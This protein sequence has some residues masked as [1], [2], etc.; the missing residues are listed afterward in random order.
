[1]LVTAR[2]APLRY[3]GV[4]DFQD[5]KSKLSLCCGTVHQLL[6]NGSEPQSPQAATKK[7]SNRRS[8]DDPGK[9]HGGRREHASNICCA[10]D[11]RDLLNPVT[12]LAGRRS[13]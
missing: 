12:R 7:P 2:G 1:M 10:S 5:V 4:T 9:E 6:R 3:P 8:N 11:A 13:A